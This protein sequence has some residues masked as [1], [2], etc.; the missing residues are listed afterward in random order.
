MPQSNV[1]T[2]RSLFSNLF[3]KFYQSL[4]KTVYKSLKKTMFRNINIQ[5]EPQQQQQQSLPQESAGPLPL[6]SPEQLRPEGQTLLQIPAP[7][8]NPFPA[9]EPQF[10]TNFV[11][12]MNQKTEQ[13]LAP[14]F[15]QSLIPSTPDV[16]LGLFACC[17]T[18][19]T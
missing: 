6:I 11:P 15:S 9:Q 5:F 18:S 4:Y 8:H 2:K 10:I 7:V 14:D 12:P 1:L 19:I 17:H 3:Q 13:L 16:N